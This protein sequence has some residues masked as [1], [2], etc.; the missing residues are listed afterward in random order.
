MNILLATGIYPPAIGGPAT[1]A[2]QLAAALTDAGHAVSVLT[3]DCGERAGERWPVFSVKKGLLFVR[4]CRY[5]LAL[6][7]LGKDVDI[8]YALSS[9]SCGIPLSLAGLKT[10][11]L[12][13]RLGGD[14]FWERYTDRG[15]SL[16][17]REWY[18]SRAS[19]LWKRVMGLILRSFDALVFST[20]F[21]RTL[22]QEQ[23]DRLPPSLVI[24]NARAPASPR[25]HERHT[26]L[27]LLSFGRFVPFKNL[28]SLIR[29]M[30]S[31]D[32]T[33][34]LAGDGP[35][36]PALRRLVAS[37]RLESTVTFLP[38]QSG[39]DAAQLFSDHDLLVVPSITDISPNAAL[40][41]VSQGLPV[42]LS[43]DTGLS[44]DLS[45]GMVKAR[46]R[47]PDDIVAAV[48]DVA[49]R[50]AEIACAAGGS[51]LTRTWDTLCAD[52]LRFFSDL[53]P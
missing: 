7:R 18:A 13:L 15:G 50:Y 36:A 48:Y 43:H 19:C 23:Y 41:A 28:S 31:L 37:L 12:I 24:E 8:V 29:A 5:A 45:T 35:Q 4:W 10:P 30:P 6:K 49:S 17:L 16:S 33:L 38:P 47:S 32:A 26:P 39:A 3:Y 1:Y 9:V 11:R 2:R 40:E 52:H 14:F 46:L 51:H 34:T 42:L 53:L 44:D 21:Q 20:D 25:L 22:Y 27:R